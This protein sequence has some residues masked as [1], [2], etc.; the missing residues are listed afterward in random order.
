MHTLTDA[1]RTAVVNLA[2]DRAQDLVTT[3]PHDYLVANVK[4]LLDR[5]PDIIATMVRAEVYKAGA[6]CGAA[7]L[8]SR[9]V[10]AIDEAHDLYTATGIKVVKALL[11]AKS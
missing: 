4:T 8:N 9:V 11:A 6:D 1:T 2:T 5:S 10:K 3:T 7:L